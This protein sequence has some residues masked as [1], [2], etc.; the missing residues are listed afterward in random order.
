M[1]LQMQFEYEYLEII[2][3]FSF[4]FNTKRQEFC[5]WSKSTYGKSYPVSKQNAAFSLAVSLTE[6]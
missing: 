1:Y 6:L 4:N 5:C 3:I 2:C